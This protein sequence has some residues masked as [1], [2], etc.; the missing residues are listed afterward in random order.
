MDSRVKAKV[1]R[2]ST[3]VSNIR[4]ALTDKGVDAT[5]HGAEDF[6]TDIVNMPPTFDPDDYA[7]VIYKENNEYK[8]RYE[9]IGKTVTTLPSTHF[10]NDTNVVS[11]ILPPTITRLSTQCFYSCNNLTHVSL[12]KITIVDSQVFSGCSNLTEIIGPNVISV[13]WGNNTGQANS[14]IKSI[15]LPKLSTVPSQM[16]WYCNEL[17]YVDISGAKT[18]KSSAFQGCTNLSNIVCRDLEDIEQYAFSGVGISGELSLPNLKV[19]DRWAF[20]NTNITKVKNLGQIDTLYTACFRLCKKLSFLRI[21]PT[22]TNI[23]AIFQGDQPEVSFTIV[24]EPTTPP[25]YENT[26]LNIASAIYVPDASVDAYKAATGWSAIASK[27]HPLSEYTG[28]D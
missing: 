27:I 23:Y 3:A 17:R 13:D 11:I 10:S 16:C 25:G 24:C 26:D 18:V 20:E 22:V 8:R 9:Y 15:V 19:L 2:L 1:D 21:P 6:A 14:K 28:S 12:E 7:F 5:G 4:S